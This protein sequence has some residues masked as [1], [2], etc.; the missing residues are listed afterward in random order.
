MRGGSHF[1][2]AVAAKAR[3]RLI[4]SSA[5]CCGIRSGAPTSGQGPAQKDAPSRRSL[6]EAIAKAGHLNVIFL[7]GLGGLGGSGKSAVVYALGLHRRGG[8][9]ILRADAEHALNLGREGG[10]KKFPGPVA[11]GRARSWQNL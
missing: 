10:A 2:A 3:C 4:Q 5:T 6:R 7:T 11:K 8:R 9:T 1:C